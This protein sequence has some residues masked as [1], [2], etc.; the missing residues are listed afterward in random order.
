LK[1]FAHSVVVCFTALL[2]YASF[3]LPGLGDPDA[4]IHRQQ[5]ATGSPVAG[6]WYIENAYRETDTPNM[7]TAV[8]ADYRGF[9]TLGETLVVLAAG[10]ACMAILGKKRR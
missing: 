2:L 8:L 3:Y 1:V 10:I 9:D 6:T 4:P 7:V 5:S